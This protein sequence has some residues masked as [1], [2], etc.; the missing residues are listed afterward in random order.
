MFAALRILSEPSIFD[1]VAT[2]SVSTAGVADGVGEMLGL[3]EGD[4]SPPPP[5]QPAAQ[6]TNAA[7]AAAKIKAFHVYLPVSLHFITNSPFLYCLSV[8]YSSTIT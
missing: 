3:G 8:F 6:S 4:A 5:P 1:T 2:L 7:A